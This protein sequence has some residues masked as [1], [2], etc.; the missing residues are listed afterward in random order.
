MK[1]QLANPLLLLTAPSRPLI[2]NINLKGLSGMGSTSRDGR[3]ITPRHLLLTLLSLMSVGPGR[4]SV[5]GY[6]WSWWARS[7]RGTRRTRNIL[8]VTRSLPCTPS[9]SRKELSPSTQVLCSHGVHTKAVFIWYSL[10]NLKFRLSSS[11][12][13]WLWLVG[14][15]SLTIQWKLGITRSLWLGNCICYIR[16]FVISAVNKQYKTKQIDS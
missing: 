12:N 13:S 11:I 9:S 8:P 5:P 16:Y 2:T 15:A 3:W 6:R 1:P 4:V 7:A 14:I 10:I